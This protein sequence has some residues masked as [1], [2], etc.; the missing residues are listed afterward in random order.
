VPNQKK[1]EV[2]AAIGSAFYL[3]QIHFYGL[4]LN[5]PQL[6]DFDAFQLART[7]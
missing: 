4:H 5:Q 2:A 7:Q 3:L 1:P 6:P